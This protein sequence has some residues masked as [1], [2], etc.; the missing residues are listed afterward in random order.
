MMRLNPD[1]RIWNHDRGLAYVRCSK[2]EQEGST[3]GQ[4]KLIRSGLAENGLALVVPSFVDDGRRG[5][6]EER[7]GLL[8]L[9]E[10]CRAHPVRVRTGG[11]YI[12][13]F[14]QSTDRLGR[15]LEPTKIFS[16]LNE[17]K[18]LGY[19]V[20]S[21]S[22]KLRFVG[23]NIG[24]WIQIAVRSDQA[25]GYSVRLSHDSLRGGLQIADLGFSAGGAPG[26]GYDRVVVSPDG[27]PRYRYTN[28][29]GK[30]VAKYTMKGELVAILEPVLRKGKLV[31]PSLDKSNSDHVRRIPGDPLKAKAVQRLFQLY[32]ENRYGLRSVADALNREGYPPPRCNHWYASAVRSILLNP[33]YK[34]DHVY[35]R[36]PKSKYHDFSVEKVGDALRFSIEKKEIFR[37]GTDSKEIADCLVRPHS[38]PPLIS[39]ETWN[40]AQEILTSKVDGNLPKRSGRG[41]RSSFLLTGFAK[42]ASCGHTYQGDTHR[43]TGRRSYQCGGYVGGGRS[44]C[45]RAS[46]PA[47]AVERW[48]REEMQ[49]RI[50]DGRTRLFESFKDFEK[51]VLDELGSSFTPETRQDT[52]KKSLESALTERKKKLHLILTGL[53]PDN[54][55]VA[56][57][58]IRTLKKEIS[59][60]EAQLKRAQ[61][62]EGPCPVHN[63]AAI[64]KEAAAQLWNLKEALAKGMI[65]EQRTI[66]D[67]F[68]KSIKVS[69]IEGWVEATFYEDSGLRRGS[70]C[71]AP[72]TGFEPV[73]RP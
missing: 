50:L 49:K 8:A 27:N 73:S 67:F 42:C 23:G 45:T 63:P 46:I 4:I 22:E 62:L 36:R 44:V 33:I 12:P 71:M 30:R 32:V 41:A 69:G 37:K 5:S 17:L 72:P 68:V 43:R 65:E 6:D 13:I 52:G 25:T 14:V 11:D 38:H 61:E 70:F 39:E 20:Y 40:L 9:L 48:I 47:E 24:D 66:I 64:A 56:N 54:M 53:E 19:D 21:L 34:G 55:D 15:F 28:L 51:A 7:P 10:Y 58:I 60:L 1:R 16:Y 29:P 57:E 2:D 18:E 59:A 35:G 31:S 3:E 26:Y